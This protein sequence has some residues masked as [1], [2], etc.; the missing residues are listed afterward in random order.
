M[1]TV[2]DSI[3]KVVFFLITLNNFA[4]FCKMRNLTNKVAIFSHFIGKV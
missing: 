1:C 3:T 4:F 2:E